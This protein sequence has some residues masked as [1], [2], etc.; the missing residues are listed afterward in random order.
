MTT[1][2]TLEIHCILLNNVGDDGGDDV[3]NDA[4]DDDDHG[5]NYKTIN[6]RWETFSS[7]H[8]NHI[9]VVIYSIWSVHNVTFLFN[10]KTF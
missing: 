10:L 7:L 4:D 1:P 9:N 5:Y 2:C 8:V 3:G 6:F